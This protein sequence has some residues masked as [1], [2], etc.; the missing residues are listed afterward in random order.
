LMLYGMSCVGLEDS[1]VVV[2]A[3]CR[4]STRRL[5]ATGACGLGA[6][7][8][9]CALHD[10]VLL[11]AHR[12]YVWM[13]ERVAWDCPQQG[14]GLTNVRWNHLSVVC[15]SLGCVFADHATASC[16]APFATAPSCGRANADCLRH[17][18]TCPYVV[19]VPKQ[20]WRYWRRQ[21]ELFRPGVRVVRHVARLGSSAALLECGYRV[22]GV[23]TGNVYHP[24]SPWRAGV[25][26]PEAK[27]KWIAEKLLKVTC[28]VVF[29]LF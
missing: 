23:E 13:R 27:N 6:W 29:G 10:T 15:R 16:D 4:T 7:V 14:R 11:Q 12:H 5:S 22:G 24:P 3:L 2:L 1:I 25:G 28:C 9:H 18:S 19:F 21:F 26:P 17:N 8:K 20:Q